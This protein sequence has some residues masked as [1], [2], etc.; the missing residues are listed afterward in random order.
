MYT[1]YLRYDATLMTLG[2]PG[3]IFWYLLCLSASACLLRYNI[4]FLLYCHRILTF[5]I[6]YIPSV[7]WLWSRGPAA[8][9]T[10]YDLLQYIH[11]I[12]CDAIRYGM[13]RRVRYMVDADAVMHRPLTE[14]SGYAL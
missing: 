4:F 10:T 2:L 13:M 5:Y 3:W 7:L 12:R 8:R 9:G 6:C 1:A 11:A 14:W